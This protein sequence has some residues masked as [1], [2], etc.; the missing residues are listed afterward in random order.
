MTDLKKE[1]G[2]KH[3]TEIQTYTNDN[4]FRKH[5]QD[6]HEK[7]GLTWDT[8]IRAGYKSNATGWSI[9]ISNPWTGEVQ[10][11]RT[12]LDNPQSSGKYTS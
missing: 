3:S 5:I 12:R 10:Y 8:I 4:L 6:L 11:Q 9:E 1:L 7:S 2:T